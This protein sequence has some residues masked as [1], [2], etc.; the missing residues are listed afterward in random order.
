MPDSGYLLDMT[1]ATSVVERRGAHRRPVV[2]RS[3]VGREDRAGVG[4][5]GRRA[6]Q[7]HVPAGELHAR[8]AGGDARAGRHGVDA[9]RRERSATRCRRRTATAAAARRP[10]STSARRCRRAGAR[11]SRAPRA[12]RPAATAVASILVTPAQAASAAFYPLTITAK[13]WAR[14]RSS[15][16]RRRRSPSNRRHAP[17]AAAA[18]A[19]RR[20]RC[21][22]RC[23]PASS[24]YRRPRYGLDPA[25]D[26]H[27]RQARRR[28]RR[29]RDGQRRGAR[30]ARPHGDAHGR[31]PDV[32]RHG[33]DRLSRSSRTRRGH[34]HG[35]EQRDERRVDRDGD[36]VVPRRV[37]PS[38]AAAQ[39]DAG[40][41]ARLKAERRST[42]ARPW[43]I[44]PPSAAS[45]S[46]SC[47]PT[48][49]TGSRSRASA[50]ALKLPKSAAH[51]FLALLAARGFVR[52]D[53]ATQRYALTL[54]LASLGFR[55]LAGT[56][57]PDL[58]QPVLDALAARTR[59]ARAA[60]D[61][62]RRHAHLGREGAG[63]GDRACATTPTPGAA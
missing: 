6:R 58:A 53:E 29:R 10:R 7:R 46:S 5:H 19:D 47:S 54:K 22:R 36:H 39:I 11:R 44:P 62:R 18:A 56:G 12:S 43:S 17:A 15:Q 49:P 16:R 41:R 28:R 1:P 13:T 33:V 4:R 14:R 24:S 21:R 34:V 45:T 2:H 40:G 8:G 32:E 57:W 51:R 42:F 20:D 23:R 59:R 27:D 63:R 26:R 3:A 61:R 37:T 30:P 35:D 31:R 9:G 50:R 25:S 55:F 52:Q 38:V 60:R 48:R